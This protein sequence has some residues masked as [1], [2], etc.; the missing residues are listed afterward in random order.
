MDA[1]LEA[2]SKQTAW[3]IGERFLRIDPLVPSTI[4]LD[5]TDESLLKQLVDIGQ[6]VELQVFSDW[7][8][9]K[10]DLKDKLTNN[11]NNNNHVNNNGALNGTAESTRSCTIV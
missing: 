6:K 1:T 7:I 4:A 10:K 5:T 2:N 11:N 3:L 8:E 9:K